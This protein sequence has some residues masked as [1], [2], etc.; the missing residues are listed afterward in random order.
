MSLHTE[1]QVD[2]SAEACV[3]AMG[4]IF[5][6]YD[7]RR[8]AG[9]QY[10]DPRHIARESVRTAMNELIAAIDT[11]DT[12]PAQ[13]RNEYR[14]IVASL[15][16]SST[17]STISSALARELAWTD[18]GAREVVRLARD[19]GCSVLRSALA[20]AEALEIEDGAAGL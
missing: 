12:Y 6:D 2:A 4:D 11:S 9:G 19:Y 1:S 8:S 18:R 16:T 5:W 15:P 7:T 20:M 17:D 14:S 13:L 3:N 10:A